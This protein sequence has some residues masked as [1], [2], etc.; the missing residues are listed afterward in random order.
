MHQA[1]QLGL[2]LHLMELTSVPKP[3]M[4]NFEAIRFI[5]QKD[6]KLSLL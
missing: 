3:R 2:F 4:T 5:T 6:L 1:T